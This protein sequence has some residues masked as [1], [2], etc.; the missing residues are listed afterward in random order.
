LKATGVRLAVATSASPEELED[1]LAIV[2][3]GHLFDVKTTADDAGRSKPDPD[4]I[5]IAVRKL[6]LKPAQC[7]MVGDTPY[8]AAA[9][10]AAGVRFIG[11]RC[12]GW[13]DTELQPAVAVFSGPAELHKRRKKAESEAPRFS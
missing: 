11:L 7:V 10:R 2:R 5:S 12:G 6:G 9:A 13:R 8:D 3:A 1:L 4:S